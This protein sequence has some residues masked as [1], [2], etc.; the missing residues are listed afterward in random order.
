MISLLLP[1]R[2]RPHLMNDFIKSYKNNSKNKNELLIY[3]QK[4]DPT[5]GQYI[6]VFKS[7]NLIENIDYFILDPFPTGHMW[8]LLADKAKG[9]LLCLMGDDVIIETIG[10]DTMI[11]EAAKKYE[12]NIFVI[13]QND[14]RSDLNNL[15]CPHPVIHKRWKEILGFFMPPMF[16]HRYLDTYTT[17]LAIE[18]NRY[19]QLPNVK[20]THNKL[21]VKKDNTGVL[22][23]S[24]LPL[25]K[26]NYEISKRYFQHDLELLR[27]HIK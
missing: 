15:G 9:D 23:R 17:R 21:S 8:N 7:F 27:K 14:G 6:D 19:I 4:D 10:W 1:T 25:D 11:E 16:M 22:S 12:D 26:Y 2:G 3:L 18:L 13:T 5:V 24:W 20:F